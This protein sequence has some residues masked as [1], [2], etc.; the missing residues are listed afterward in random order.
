MPDFIVL[1]TYLVLPLAD[2]FTAAI[3]TTVTTNVKAG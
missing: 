1:R 2:Q 3:Q